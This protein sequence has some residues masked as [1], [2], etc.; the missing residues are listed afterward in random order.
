[1]EP[2]KADW[3]TAVNDCKNKNFMLIPGRSFRAKGLAKLL[4]EGESVW[5][6]GWRAVAELEQGNQ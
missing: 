6:N 4:Q 3:D 2:N 5:I 1:L